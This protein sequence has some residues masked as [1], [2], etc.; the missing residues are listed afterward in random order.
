ENL[1]STR[2]ITGN[3]PAEFGDRSAAVVTLSTK[4]G[5]DIPWNGSA[6]FSA[7]SFGGAAVDVELGGHVR[8]I[9]IFLTADTSHSRRFL[10]PPEIDNLHNVGGLEHVFVRFDWL[11]T[12]RDVFHLTLSTNGT[13]FQVPNLFEQQQEGQRQRQELRDDYQSI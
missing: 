10:D 4:S 11:L 1:E 8:N 5:L 7:G 9:G 13:D 2:I 3:V 6:A 12:K